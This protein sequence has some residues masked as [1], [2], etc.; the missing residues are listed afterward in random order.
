MCRCLGRLELPHRPF[1]TPVTVTR[2]PRMPKAYAIKW[3]FVWNSIWYLLL[4]IFLFFILL[5]L[6]HT[7]ADWILVNGTMVHPQCG[8]HIPNPSKVKILYILKKGRKTFVRPFACLVLA[9]SAH[10]LKLNEGPNGG[11]G[12]L[13]HTSHVTH[14]HTDT[15]GIFNLWGGWLGHSWQSR[16]WLRHTSHRHSWQYFWVI[17]DAVDRS[18]NLYDTKN[19]PRW[20][21][22]ENLLI[23]LIWLY[24]NRQKTKDGNW[25][26]NPQSITGWNCRE[27]QLVKEFFAAL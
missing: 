25:L 24:Q 14:K 11:R 3:P 21:I 10:V 15:V 13:R 4:V 23:L 19:N 6:P 1:A 20:K 7:L 18:W 22:F 2:M 8:F 17:V 9:W 12:W 27:V 16:G 26:W 5:I